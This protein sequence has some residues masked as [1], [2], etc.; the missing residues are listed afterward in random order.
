MLKPSPWHL[1]F[2]FDAKEYRWSLHKVAGKPP[3]YRMS[4]TE[5]QAIAERL[6]FDTRAG[7]LTDTGASSPEQT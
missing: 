5:A 6:R 4:K 1:G 7:K 3:G 2:A